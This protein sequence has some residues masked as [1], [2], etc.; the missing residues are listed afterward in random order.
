[1]VEKK[2]T[3]EIIENLAVSREPLSPYDLTKKTKR[4]YSGIRENTIRLCKEGYVQLKS[5]EKSK[6]GVNRDLYTL[7]FKGVL[8]YLSSFYIFLD[9]FP[10][11]STTKTKKTLMNVMKNLM[12]CIKRIYLTFLKGKVR[13][14]TIFHSKNAGGFWNVPLELSG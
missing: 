9:C 10:D 1:M 8:K 13:Y 2:Y 3:E 7:T 14:S 5:T 6:T 12:F 11:G 4:S